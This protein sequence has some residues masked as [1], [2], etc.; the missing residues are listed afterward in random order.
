M[1]VCDTGEGEQHLL[2]V[3]HTLTHTPPRHTHKPPYLMPL[4]LMELREERSG[5]WGSSSLPGP[6]VLWLPSLYT[7]KIFKAHTL[8]CMGVFITSS[9]LSG[10]SAC[11][12]HRLAVWVMFSVSLLSLSQPLI[13][14]TFK[15]HRLSVAVLSSSQVVY[16]F[17]CQNRSRLNLS[18]SQITSGL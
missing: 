14:R 9:E 4:Y 2:S 10:P 13:F 16:L 11:W 7:W 8:S 6:V 15:C 5:G 17:R 12:L 3:T 1:E 18:V